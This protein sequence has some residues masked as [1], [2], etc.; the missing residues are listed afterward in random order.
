MLTFYTIRAP[1]KGGVIRGRRRAYARLM[2]L[3]PRMAA[4]TRI[5]VPPSVRGQGYGTKLLKLVLADA[6]HTN[7]SLVIN[8]LSDGTGLSNDQLVAWYSRH[9]FLPKPGDITFVRAPVPK[10]SPRLQAD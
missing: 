8:P 6:D 10:P 5:W 1:G 7:T 3:N 4:L 2:H 9:G